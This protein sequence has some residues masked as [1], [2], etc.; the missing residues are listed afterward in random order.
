MQ[1]EKSDCPTEVWLSAKICLPDGQR[2]FAVGKLVEQKDRT[3]DL[4]LTLDQ[5]FLANKAEQIPNV[6]KLNNLLLSSQQNLSA[7]PKGTAI[8]LAPPKLFGA[9]FWIARVGEPVGLT[10]NHNEDIIS[11]SVTYN[12]LELKRLKNFLEARSAPRTVFRT[13]VL[14]VDP[15]TYTVTHFHTHDISHNGLSIALDAEADIDT[16]FEVN[17]NYLLQLQIHEGF[18]MPPLNYRCIH[19]REDILTGARLIGFALND[20]KAKDPDVEYNL[21]LLTWSDAPESSEAVEESE[22]DLGGGD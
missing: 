20:R 13:P 6:S 19:M 17:E 18:S 2:G 15:K 3:I 22:H 7:L 12:L 10:K 1:R 16:I 11:N 9:K 14:L 21:T 5:S 4:V 8:L